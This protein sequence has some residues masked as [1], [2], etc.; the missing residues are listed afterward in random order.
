MLSASCFSCFVL[1][2]RS[3]SRTGRVASR[4]GE[5]LSSDAVPNVYRSVTKVRKNDDVCVLCLVGSAWQTGTPTAKAAH[6]QP[7]AQGKL[8]AASADRT[9]SSRDTAVCL[10]P[11]SI[12]TAFCSWI[13]KGGHCVGGVVV[14]S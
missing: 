8:S 1:S 5:R 13:R 3:P 14:V 12:T 4:S 7:V 10:Q 9:L 6:E 11:F 2:S